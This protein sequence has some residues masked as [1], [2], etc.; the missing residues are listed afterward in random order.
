MHLN[1]KTDLPMRYRTLGSGAFR[2]VSQSTLLVAK[3]NGEGALPDERLMAQEATNLCADTRAVGFTMF[4]VGAYH[5]VNWGSQWEDVDVDEL[6]TDK[7][8]S[9]KDQAQR[10][11]RQWL[12]NGPV[13][14]RD[15]EEWSKRAGIGWRTITEAKKAIGAIAIPPERRNGPWQWR[16]G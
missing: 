12:A 3:D 7:R 13:L 5:R 1:K 4:G 16:L 11:L 10:L 14:A 8:Q 9:K 2:N 6:M 15:L